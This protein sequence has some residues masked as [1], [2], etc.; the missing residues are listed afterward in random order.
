[1]KKTRESEGRFLIEGWHLLEEAL[2][3]GR[4]LHALIF[5]EAARREPEEGKLLARCVSVAGE[6]FSGTSTQLGQLS[7]TKSSQ[8][9]VALIDHVGVDAESLLPVWRRKETLRLLALDAVA[10]PGNCGAI[11]RTCDW[12]G[13]DGVLLGTGCAELE[14]GKTARAT[15]GGLFHLPVATRVDLPLALGSLR[16]DGVSI[17]STELEGAESLA[18]LVF[19][20]RCALVIGNEARGVSSEVSALASA[21]L[22]VPCFG[23][24][25][26]LN[27][28]TAA[29]V[30]MARWRL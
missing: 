19:P 10:D 25:E 29:A 24:G 7:D 23:G 26:S 12:F 4:R 2:K 17:L 1:M 3:S 14:N 27:A 22:F 9:V 8:G 28:A 15:M 13:F 18:G 30:F 20:E 21:R 16:E 11:I 6:S 5:D